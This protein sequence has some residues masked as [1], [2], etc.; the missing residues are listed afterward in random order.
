VFLTLRK[1]SSEV[2]RSSGGSNE[3]PESSGSSNEVLK[4]VLEVPMK[5][6]KVLEVLTKVLEVPTKFLEVLVFSVMRFLCPTEIPFINMVTNS[7][8][9]SFS[10]SGILAIGY[11]KILLIVSCC[12]RFHTSFPNIWPLYVGNIVLTVLTPPRKATGKTPG[13]LVTIWSHWRSGLRGG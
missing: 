11:I 5:F 4:K 7:F 6:L 3:V 8:H 12:S 2:S 10:Y 13:I 1:L 9:S